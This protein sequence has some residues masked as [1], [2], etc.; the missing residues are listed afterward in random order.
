M[1]SLLKTTSSQWTA[2]VV[3][4]LVSAAAMYFAFTPRSIFGIPE[5]F[6]T[7]QGAHVS[8]MRPQ[9]FNDDKYP[10]ITTNKNLRI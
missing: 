8:M 1:G 2:L 3:I 7:A 5:G 10:I 4:V 6:R 9:K